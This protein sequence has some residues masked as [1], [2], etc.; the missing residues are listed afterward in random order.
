MSIGMWG[1]YIYCILFEC[2]N[3]YC[4]EISFGIYSVPP[5]PWHTF[6]VVIPGSKYLVSVN[7]FYLT[8]FKHLLWWIFSNVNNWF[9]NI[10]F[11]YLNFI[12]KFY[13]FIF[14][15]GPGKHD[16]PLMTLGQKSDNIRTTSYWNLIHSVAC[17]FIFQDL[18][19]ISSES[20]VCV[21]YSILQNYCN[22]SNDLSPLCDC[23]R[24]A[25]IFISA[26]PR[27][28]WHDQI[29]AGLCRI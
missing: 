29:L 19:K 1:R 11:T 24:P 18:L 28:P 4:S 9:M 22:I 21:T 26:A 6:G 14:C 17:F 15:C 25:K 7:F 10:N 16:H 5:S 27:G 12:H 2:Q 20:W 13:W 23:D 3:I 8:G